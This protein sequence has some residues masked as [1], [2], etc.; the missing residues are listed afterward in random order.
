MDLV[1]YYVGPSQPGGLYKGLEWT[2]IG[3][4]GLMSRKE[5]GIQNYT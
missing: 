4:E 1:I 3:G 5:P 2:G